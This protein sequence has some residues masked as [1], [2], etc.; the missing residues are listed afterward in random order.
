[1]VLPEQGIDIVPTFE[2]TEKKSYFLCRCEALRRSNA[3]LV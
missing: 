3:I 1:M 2:E